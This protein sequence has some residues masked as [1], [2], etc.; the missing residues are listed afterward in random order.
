MTCSLVTCMGTLLPFQ[1][2]YTHVHLL[3]L[4]FRECYFVKHVVKIENFPKN[5]CIRARDFS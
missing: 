5:R 3:M 4:L 1:M 2:M